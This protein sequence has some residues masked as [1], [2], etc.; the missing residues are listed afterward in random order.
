MHMVQSSSCPT[1]QT[2]P[3]LVMYG[4]LGNE[5][6]FAK[7]PVSS[8]PNKLQ[9][10]L[11]KDELKQHRSRYKM[12]LKCLGGIKFEMT[13]HVRNKQTKIRTVTTYI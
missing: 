6:G 13:T 10:I 11:R 8:L 12:S 3:L 2:C 5:K 4:A 9:I 7:T 1:F